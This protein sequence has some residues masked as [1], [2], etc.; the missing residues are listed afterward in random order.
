[1]G[2]LYTYDLNVCETSNDAWEKIVSLEVDLLKRVKDEV[3]YVLRHLVI[4][5]ILSSSCH[6]SQNHKLDVT[7]NIFLTSRHNL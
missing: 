5:T 1:M 7:A 3:I 2:V 4:D 6:I